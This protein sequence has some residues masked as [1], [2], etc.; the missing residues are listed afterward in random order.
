[1]SEELFGNLTKGVGT[2]VD[3]SP[4]ASSPSVI[5]HASACS[6]DWKMARAGSVCTLV[7]IV[8]CHIRARP[9][10]NLSLITAAAGKSPSRSLISKASST[11]RRISS[12]VKSSTTR[13]CM[14]NQDSHARPPRRVISKVRRESLKALQGCRAAGFDQQVVPFLHVSDGGR[15]L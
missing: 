8:S 14:V 11:T 1:M 7:S 15:H 12:V 3:Y 13:I 10:A 4:S 2:L 9:N 6:L 5:S